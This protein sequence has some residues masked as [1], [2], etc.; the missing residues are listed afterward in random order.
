MQKIRQIT[1][2]EVISVFLKAEIESS[3]FRDKL[4]SILENH[5][6][7]LSSINQPD[8]LNVHENEDRRKIIGEYRG[9]GF[10]KDLFEDFPSEVSWFRVNLTP[11][12][13]SK[14]QY[15]NWDYWL[16]VTNDTRL[17]LVLVK[18]IRNNTLPDNEEVRRFKA[19]A[20]EIESGKKFQEMIMVAK[21]EKSRLV[22]LEGHL[23]LTAYIL[24]KKPLQASIE[25]IIGFSDQI[26]KWGNY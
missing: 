11:E 18:K 1:E 20:K 24:S 12:E 13:L 9:F 3:R 26:T 19:V 16:E 22:V 21:D 7:S 23:R 15:I 17:P 2:D 14:V 8:I 6:V 4:L 25:V 10:K 5:H